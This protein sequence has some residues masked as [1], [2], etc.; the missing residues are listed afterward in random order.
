MERNFYKIGQKKDA[1]HFPILH[2]ELEITDNSARLYPYYKD[3]NKEYSKDNLSKTFGVPIKNNDLLINLH[4]NIPLTNMAD[5]AIT[6]KTLFFWEKFFNI[7]QCIPLRFFLKDDETRK[8][9]KIL[10]KG[11][12]KVL[13]PFFGRGFI[14]EFTCKDG[15]HQTFYKGLLNY[16]RFCKKKPHCCVGGETEEEFLQKEALVKRK[17][18]IENKYGHVRHGPNGFDFSQVPGLQ[19][20][21]KILLPNA[22]PIKNPNNTVI[23][24]PEDFNLNQ[25]PKTKPKESKEISTIALIESQNINNRLQR[26]N[27]NRTNTRNEGPS[28][29]KQTT[30]FA[31]L[32]II[33]TYLT[34]FFFNI[35]QFISTT[36]K[37]II[38][39]HKRQN[40]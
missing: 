28:N 34:S 4:C 12:D 32:F 13:I 8:D 11:E 38:N 10:P 33:S 3:S 7:P 31:R 25:I 36:L 18:L 22:V 40:C 19:D 20:N 16:I 14:V 15:I 24:N 29:K 35:N 1:K 27:R 17:I 39:M 23:H 6:A 30:F 2:G 21:D 26:V 37:K 9:Y 5:N